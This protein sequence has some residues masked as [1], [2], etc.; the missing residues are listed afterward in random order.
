[1]SLG[2]T[3][4]RLPFSPV[5]EDHAI[6]SVKFSLKAKS[7]LPRRAFFDV[8]PLRAAFSDALPAFSEGVAAVDV[9][10]R[11]LEVPTIEFSFLQPNGSP[12]WSLNV[13]GNQIDVLCNIYTRWDKVWSRADKY[14]YQ[15][16]D[17]FAAHSKEGVELVEIE[18]TVLDRFLSPARSSVFDLISGH[19][20]LPE[21]LAARDYPWHSHTGWFEDAENEARILQNLNIDAID[22]PTMGVSVSIT[23]F[24][25][26]VNISKLNARFEGN[27]QFIQS[28]MN[29]M[30]ERNK[31]MLVDLLHDSVLRSIGLEVV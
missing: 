6:E 21:R 3:G 25:K 14:L 30:H 5:N 29:E 8:D 28:C 19:G 20:S 7:A 2:P 9:G 15:C 23:H 4:E 18:M 10:G 17:H 26:F 27:R 16:L 12:T 24:Q 13:G 31:K 1:M 22:N 11:Q